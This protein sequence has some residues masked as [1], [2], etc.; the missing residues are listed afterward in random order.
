M[1]YLTRPRVTASAVTLVVL[2][3]ERLEGRSTSS[4]VFPASGGTLGS[5]GSD[6]W[7]LQDHAGRIRPAHAEIRLL[8]GQFC[9]IDRSGQTLINHATL[10]LGRDRRVALRDGDELGVGEYRVRVHLGDRQ[11]GLP[12]A[13]PLSAL[14]DEEQEAL[15][16]Q[17]VVP[18]RVTPAVAPPPR[19]DDPLEALGEAT[20][21]ASQRDPLTALAHESEAESDDGTLLDTLEA[22]GRGGAMP[23]E[24]QVRRVAPMNRRHEDDTE[25]NREMD[26]G[27]LN[28]LERSV[29]EQLEERWQDAVPASAGTAGPDPLLRAL[30]AELRFA[31]SEEQLNFLAEAGHT[32]RAAIEGLQALHRAQDDSRYPLRDRRLQP[33][34]DNPLRLGQPYRSTVETLFSA[35]R[36]PV[37]LSAPA[38]VAECLSHQGQHQAAVEE[39]IGEALQAILDAFAP[40][41][42][43]KR[44]HAYRGAGNRLDDEGNWAWE[45]YRHYYEELNSGRQQGFAKLFWEVFEQAYD[46]SVRRQQREAK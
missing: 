29:G 38:A 21:G 7:L 27:L 6:D 32:L 36:S 13:Q 26:E 18:Y 43:L 3:S 1:S 31:D 28:D 34:E 8:D 4:H 45:M 37:H 25:M 40:D 12:G 23:H 22:P 35:R 5:A 19:R 39:A 24:T 17:G 42:L 30:G 14:I 9:L 10:P 15:A 44:F 46:Q 11:A 2:N 16:G 33:I 20:P 41:A